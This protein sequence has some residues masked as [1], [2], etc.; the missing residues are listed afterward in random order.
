MKEW[1][2]RKKT[3]SS[4]FFVLLGCILCLI[5]LYPQTIRRAKFFE[6]KN[7]LKVYLHEK[8]THPFVNLSFGIN[9]GSKDE[10][11][12]TNGLVHILEHYM[13]FR[14]SESRDE[15][16]ISQDIRR[17]GAYFNA[18]TGYDLTIF[19]MTLQS[20]YLDFAL[21]NQ[22]DIVFNLRL[23]QEKIDEEKQVILE[24][25]NQI[26][27]DPIKYTTTLVYQNLFKNFPYQRPICGKKEIIEA[28]T[29]E[30]MENFYKKYF[31]PSNCALAVVGNIDI[32]ET[33]EKIKKIF[34]DLRNEQSSFVK[35]EKVG[36]LKNSVEIE[37][38]MDVNQAYLVIGFTGPD[39]N[40]PDRYAMDVL[41]EIIGR[42]VNPLLISSLKG[43][44]HLVHSLS[45]G[46]N[47]M[48]YGGAI[49]IFLT[50]D[51]KNVETVKTEAIQFLKKT[52]NLNYSKKD[53]FDQ[54]KFR[55]FDYLESAKNQIKL[56]SH[57]MSEKG[58]NVSTSLV[59]FMLLEEG[60]TRVNYIEN[61]EKI[62]SSG[63]RKIA[64]KYFSQ[65][66]Y[67][68]LSVVPKKK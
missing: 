27:D 1:G 38:T 42:G 33:E 67:V 11:D 29:V 17:H 56:K 58:L 55:A 34:G 60:T 23:I 57:K 44:S 39:F 25:L 63:L 22:K 16:E 18:Y 4:F 37:K 9:L 32:E 20:N 31:A 46:Y 2:T 50:L 61:I 48:K 24:E 36:L 12:E 13:L 65:G 45:I 59:M 43:K 52:K 5:T 35:F 47:P 30:Q 15:T 21:E 7:G 3:I 68:I 8:H 62:E 28:A 64:G 6:L 51:S 66:R 19:E 53:Y 14:G 41:V 26:Q 54:S 49:L 40:H 10:S